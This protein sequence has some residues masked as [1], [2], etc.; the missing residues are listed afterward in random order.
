MPVIE[1][2][3]TG[4]FVITNLTRQLQPAIRYPMGDVAEWVDRD[5]R[6]FWVAAA[7]EEGRDDILCL[8]VS[9]AN[10]QSLAYQIKHL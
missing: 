10:A 5:E 6:F 3:V 2:G 1:S 9:R 7:R 8:S 4:H